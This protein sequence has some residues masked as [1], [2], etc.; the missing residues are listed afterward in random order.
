MMLTLAWRNLW[1]RRRR[2]LFSIVAIAITAAVVV[3]LPSLQAGS[4][5]SMVRTYIGF[6][7]GYAQVQHKDYLSTPAMRDS[8]Q[9]TEALRTALKD[10]PPDVSVGQRGVAY[11]LL[12]SDTRSIGAQIL[13][14]EPEAEPSISTIP[15]NIVQ[16]DYLSKND[17]VVLG[18]V[19]A[20]NLQVG[21]GDS[22]TLLGVGHDAS[23]AADVLT[24]A[25]VF[26]TGIT[27][28][29][30]TLAEIPLKRFDATFAMDGE[31][32]SIVLNGGDMAAL[33]HE[34]R[35]LRPLVE[36]E[37]L[38]LRDWTE[39]QPSLDAAIRLDATSAV[40]IYAVLIVVVVISLLNT[41]L[42]SVLERTREFGMMLALGV[43]PGLLGR[44]VWVE[45]G[46][47]SLLGVLAGMLGGVILTFWLGRQG[48]EFESAQAV[49]EQYGMSGTLYPEL[50]SLTLF[51]GPAVIVLALLLAG[52]YPAFRIQGL[53]I[54]EAM[55]AA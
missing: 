20:R 24:V 27:D 28:I 18:E 26:R 35:G 40:L 16:G 29:D 50:T 36:E 19:L 22:I 21:I 51:A 45:I 52:T 8:F 3:F 37:G 38:A 17:Q 48:I 5:S 11:V 39:L 55:R 49:F 23:L 43:K 54:I 42:I 53:R 6:T 2:T 13:G 4:Y 14:V 32:H 41:L 10:L 9:V 46:L 31:R 34:V 12:S 25:G 7:D 44:I 1:R 47:L 33:R 15:S 30:R